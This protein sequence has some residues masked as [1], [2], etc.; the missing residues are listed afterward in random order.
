MTPKSG[1]FI[2]LSVDYHSLH[3]IYAYVM[4]CLEYICDVQRPIAEEAELEYEHLKDKSDGHTF[5]LGLVNTLHAKQRQ[6]LDAYDAT[7]PNSET[8]NKVR[9]QLMAIDA[10]VKAK[11]KQLE[12]LRQQL[13]SCRIKTMTLKRTEE[14]FQR[15]N[16]EYQKAQEYFNQELFD[17]DIHAI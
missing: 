14:E 11:D 6:L 12:E 10:Q 2:P 17:L 3:E 5:M 16:K 4:R 8:R 13:K 9:R 7:S 1:N 15:I